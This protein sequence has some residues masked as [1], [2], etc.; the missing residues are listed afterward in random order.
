VDRGS[1]R[2]RRGNESVI[3]E[4]RRNPAVMKRTCGEVAE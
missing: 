4:W 2:E 3:V 1:E